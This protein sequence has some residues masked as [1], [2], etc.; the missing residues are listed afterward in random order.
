MLALSSMTISPSFN[1][2]WFVDALKAGVFEEIFFRLFFFALCIIVTKDEPL[3][4]MQNIL[5]YMVMIVPHVLIHF[6]LQTFNI[7][8]FVTL[9]LMFGIPFVIIQRKVNLISAIG[10]HSFIDLLRFCILGM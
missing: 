5:C 2:Q 7:G 4:R 3:S 1:I 9:S 10:A 6:N 8:S